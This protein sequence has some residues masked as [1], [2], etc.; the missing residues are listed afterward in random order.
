MR[1][2]RLNGSVYMTGYI[3][4]FLLQSHALV[5]IKNYL[6]FIGIETIH[7]KEFTFIFRCIPF[8]VR[9]IEDRYK[10]YKINIIYTYVL[11]FF[12]NVIY[13]KCFLCFGAD[14]EIFSFS[15]VQVL[16]CLQNNAMLV[17]T[18]KARLFILSTKHRTYDQ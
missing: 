18:I 8:F 7:N 9:S 6:F 14:T 11:N 13:L 15:L 1:I 16:F 3:P 10:Y 2:L 12:Y 4:R 17:T 5:Y